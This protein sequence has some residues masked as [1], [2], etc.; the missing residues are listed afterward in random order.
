MKTKDNYKTI[1]FIALSI[2]FTAIFYFM[3]K[4]QYV[5]DHL[6]TE[7][8]CGIPVFTIIV[9]MS[10]RGYRKIRSIYIHQK[11]LYLKSRKNK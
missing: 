11:D 8:I 4:S 10:M 6:T 5:L 1:I 7:I 9:I 3:A 2:I